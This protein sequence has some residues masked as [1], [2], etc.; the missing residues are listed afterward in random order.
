[1][2]VHRL[3]GTEA[4]WE[5]Y[6]VRECLLGTH[7]A[8]G[9]VQVWWCMSI[10]AAVGRIQ[11]SQLTH[12][13]ALPLLITENTIPLRILYEKYSECLTESNLIKVRGLLVEPASNSYLLAERDLYLENP[14][15]KIRVRSIWG[16][17]TDSPRLG[18]RQP[19]YMHTPASLQPGAFLGLR[20]LVERGYQKAKRMQD[21]SLWKGLLEPWGWGI[22]R[23]P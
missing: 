2:P 14:E 16:P 10:I 4:N 8:L 23:Y 7:E 12:H 22:A 15:I 6:S 18:K 11:P 20:S 3:E 17:R 1:M 21:S 13:T 5:C 9:T 19:A